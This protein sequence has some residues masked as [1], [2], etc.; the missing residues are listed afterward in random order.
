METKENYYQG[1]D[2]TILI[3]LNNV[4]KALEYKHSQGELTSVEAQAYANLKELFSEPFQRPFLQGANNFTFVNDM[5]RNLFM[6]TISSTLKYLIVTTG[7]YD[8]YLAN[9]LQV[10]SDMNTQVKHEE[11]VTEFA[12]GSAVDVSQM[13]REEFERAAR[14]F[15][16]G[17]SALQ[18]FLIYTHDIELYTMACCKGHRCKNG[19]KSTAYIAFSLKEHYDEKMFLMSKAFESGMEVAIIDFDDGLGFDIIPSPYDREEQ[20]ASLTRSLKEYKKDAKLNPVITQVMEYMEHIGHSETIYSGIELFK[21]GDFIGIEE[22]TPINQ[23][24]R[25]VFMEEDVLN[26]Y[27]QKDSNIL[28]SSQVVPKSKTVVTS[29]D[30]AKSALEFTKKMPGRFSQAMKSTLGLFNRVINHNKK[31]KERDL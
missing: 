6:S 10:I 25:G 5:D 19:T 20:I 15:S 23:N 11:V 27:S 3:D 8:S 28:K 13:S 22:H 21:E 17:S 26:A 4:L 16:E 2:R 29:R 7:I 31:E 12:N 24:M 18:D 1:V 14:E 9:R 30:V